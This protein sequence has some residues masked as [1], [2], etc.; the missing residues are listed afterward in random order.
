MKSIEG[1]LW[2]E[3][4]S[5][6]LCVMCGAVVFCPVVGL[7]GVAGA[8]EVSELLLRFATLKQMELH[9]HCFHS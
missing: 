8:P 5:A 3:D 4:F 6:L 1:A 7:I 2:S 9:V